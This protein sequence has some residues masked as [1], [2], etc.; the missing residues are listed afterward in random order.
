ML[1][2]NAA[3]QNIFRGKKVR[4]HKQMKKKNK[5]TGAT[6]TLCRADSITRQR[7]FLVEIHGKQKCCRA[8]MTSFT[9]NHPSKPYISGNKTEK[10]DAISIE[11]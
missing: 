5:N 7:R 4:L 8:T 6:L 9:P 10:Y 11:L 2:V 3:E 1:Q